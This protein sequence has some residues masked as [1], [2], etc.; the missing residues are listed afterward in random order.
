MIKTELLLLKNFLSKNIY[1]VIFS[2]ILLV[3][4]LFFVIKSLISFEL[5]GNAIDLYKELYYFMMFLYIP[6]IYLS[7]E[8]IFRSKRVDFLRYFSIKNTT[9]L[10]DI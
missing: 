8:N 9:I 2:V 1:K 10:I 6:I 4:A 7:M 3:I 5:E